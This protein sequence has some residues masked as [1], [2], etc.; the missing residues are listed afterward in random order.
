MRTTFFL[1]VA[2]SAVAPFLVSAAPTAS[3]EG[4]VPLRQ[5][6]KRDTKNNA[7]TSSG[8]KSFKGTNT[9]SIASWYR[10]N[11]PADHTNGHSWCY[12]NY[13][14]STPGFAVSRQQMI[15]DFDGDEMAARKAYC[16][17]EAVVT[18]P[19]GQSE[20][21]YIADAF[22]DQ[23]VRTPTSMDVIKG[24]FV[25]LYGRDTNNK[26]D[27]IQGVQWQ[28]TGKRAAQWS[29]GGSGSA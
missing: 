27:V 18:T 24:A 21:L 14:D 26:D 4:L 29:F 3:T 11:D 19:E 9:N 28:W 16:G 20:T 8:I 6:E 5:L 2:L 17:L 25:K 10:T 23:Y 13:D 15:S 22:D 1:G 7:V 12:T